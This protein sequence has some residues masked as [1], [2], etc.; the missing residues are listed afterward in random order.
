M[1]DFDRLVAAAHERGLR[2]D[3][4]PRHEP[5]QRPHPWFVDSRS[6]ATAPTPT[7]TCGATRPA[8][9]GASPMPP[10]NWASLFGGPGWAWE[11]EPEAVLPAHVPREQP[12]LNWRHPAV[13]AAQLGDDPGLAG[14][15]CRRFPARRVQR[16]LQGP[17]S[18][19]EPAPDDRRGRGPA[20]GVEPPA[21]PPRPG[22]PGSQ[23]LPR[24]VPGDRRRGPRPDDGRRAVRRSARGRPAYTE[25][26]H[27]VFEFELL[28][29]ALGGRR[30]G[31]GHRRSRGAF[32]PD[33]WPAV[34]L[35]NHD[36]PR[37]RQPL[38]QGARA[39]RRGQ[40]GGRPAAHP[41]RD[42]VPVLRRGDRP[43]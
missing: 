38:R 13:R 39:G 23:G 6:A 16:V 21:A 15:R 7:G 8:G 28:T 2:V 31:R 19:V 24:R 27:L 42:A 26:G 25:P 1:A 32:G 29:A 20:A 30:T 41:A 17:G 14:T 10:N 11:P 22:S 18:A 40:G 9:A 35:S 36:Q 33:R 34:V 5:H 3:P 4:R 12:E 43:R 37:Q